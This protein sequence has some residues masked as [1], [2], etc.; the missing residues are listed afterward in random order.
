M[1]RATDLPSDDVDDRASLRP[2]DTCS[3]GF[4][5]PPR[6]VTPSERWAAEHRWTHSV[7]ECVARGV[8]GVPDTR[9]DLVEMVD[10]AGVF[11]RVLQKDDRTLRATMA[12]LREELAIL[13]APKPPP[14]PD[15]D[16]PALPLDGAV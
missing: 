16:Q 4:H 7:A 5:I 14:A 3:C 12:A 10:A 6:G 8:R 9:A 1:P 2:R 13:G 11:I 15:P